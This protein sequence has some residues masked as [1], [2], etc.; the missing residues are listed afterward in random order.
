M[1]KK[2]R[3]Q[4]AQS[5]ELDWWEREWEAH[6][7]YRWLGKRAAFF[8]NWIELYTELSS[9]T[10]IL[11]IG[12]AGLPIVDFMQTGVCYGIDPLY[13]SYKEL[14]EPIYTAATRKVTY[15]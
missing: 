13:N 6:V 9:E 14:F 10:K 8:E 7:D 4:L 15:R 5:G 3:W 2:E 11:E 1:I 12:G